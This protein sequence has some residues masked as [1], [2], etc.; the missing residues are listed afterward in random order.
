MGRVNSYGYRKSTSSRLRKYIPN[1]LSGAMSGSKILR[2]GGRILKSFVKERAMNEP[3][4]LFADAYG[5]FKSAK[6]LVSTIPVLND[7][8]KEKAGA[9]YRLA[10]QLKNPV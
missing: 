4:S 2:S 6:K 3:N 7:T 8:L 5:T 1:L 10:D 9:V